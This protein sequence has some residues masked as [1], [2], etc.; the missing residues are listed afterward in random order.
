MLR[1][2]RDLARDFA[3][4]LDLNLTIIEGPVDTAAAAQH[5]PATNCQCSLELAFD[6]S[7]IN[8]GSADEVSTRTQNE[9]PRRDIAFDRAFNLDYVAPRDLTLQLNARA[10]VEIG[11]AFCGRLGLR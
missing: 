4:A 3:P 7:L 10:C 8:L 1:L 9:L 6:L 5:K 2:G 11:R